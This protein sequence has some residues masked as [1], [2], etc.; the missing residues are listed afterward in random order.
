M[1]GRRIQGE[2]P[3]PCRFFVVREY[4]GKDEARSGRPF[5]GRVGGELS[6]FF[7]GVR[8][9]NMRQIYAT[10]WIKEWCGP[11]LDYTSGDY[12]R[13]LPELNTEIKAVQPTIVI[14]LGREVTRLFL[15]DVDM[16]ECHGIPWFLPVDNSQTELFETPKTVVIFPVYNPAAGFRSPELSA[17]V[18]YDCSQL[19]GVL[20]GTILPR[21]LYDDPIPYPVY[22]LIHG[23]DVCELLSRITGS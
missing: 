16:E 21:I 14:T 3:I 13:D 6:R 1:I 22:R 5:S 4:P 17:A 23:E 9:P 2:G 15:G 11:D 19:E 7:D 18:A 10:S 20:D 8:L 12:A